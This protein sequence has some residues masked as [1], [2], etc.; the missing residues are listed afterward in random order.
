MGA[1]DRIPDGATVWIKNPDKKSEEA[2]VK[3]TVKAFTPGRGYT[4]SAEGKDKVVRPVDVAHAN[5]DGMSAP[6]ACFLI[7]IS[8]ATILDNLRARY[9]QNNIY[10]FTGSILI[11]V[12]PFQLLPVY[13]HDK[14]EPYPN[15]ALGI[16]EPHAYAMAEE[17]YKTYV[18]SKGSQALVVSGES[19]SGKTE[20]N[21][22]L[23]QYI[24][25]RSK[26]ESVGADLAE[27]ILGAK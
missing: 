22:H 12:N 26:S 17:A 6:D 24:A 2:F 27:A 20:T 16:A 18:K 21:K 1:D 11:A 7:H 4:I 5:P 14:M 19:G 23:M 3:A 15:K 9:K 8:E 13:G 25:W 10:T